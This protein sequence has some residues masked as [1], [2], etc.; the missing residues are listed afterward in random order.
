MGVLT[1]ILKASAAFL[2]S[3]VSV[4]LARYTARRLNVKNDPNPIVETHR[5]PVPYLGGV[6]VFLPFSI[7]LILFCG[8]GTWVFLFLGAL[9]GLV[10]LGTIDDLRPLPW[11]LKLL[12]EAVVCSVSVPMIFSALQITNDPIFIILAILVVLLLTNGFN[13]IDVSDG[14]C[15]SVGAMIAIG[16][17]W[18]FLFY[19]PLSHL[20]TAPLL[21]AGTL[22]GFL[23]FNKPKASIY[24]GDGGSLPLGYAVGTLIVLWLFSANLSL[25]RVIVS[26]SLPSL[27]FF[28]IA[29]LSFHRIRK[30]KSIFHGS[31]DH[32]ALRLVKH[33]WSVTG[34]LLAAL[35]VSSFL[36]A[37]IALLW[38][39][40]FASW[41]YASLLLT[42][43]AISFRQLSKIKVDA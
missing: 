2:A 12:I 40:V 16:L 41:I 14:L 42:F 34:T 24:L 19:S 43:Y 27:I 6:G 21:L 30:G 4:W 15:C 11:W 33:G 36:T 32:F 8:T 26:A 3:V 23:V 7:L 28:E 22:G 25:P 37:S 35:A 17:F 1:G 9:W 39:P 13:L 20:D 10:I 5:Q 29:L 38:L 31:P 18:A